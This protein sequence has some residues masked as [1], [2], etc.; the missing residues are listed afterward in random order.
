[1]EKFE[2]YNLDLS[3]KE[4]ELVTKYLDKVNH[5]VKKHDIDN[6]LYQDIEE[7]VFEKLS[8]E[9]KLDQLKIIK[10]LKEVGEPEI[11][12]SDYLDEDDKKEST[13]EKELFFIKLEKNGWIRNNK[14]AWVLG[15]SE[16]LADKAGLPILF[17]RIILILLIFVGGISIWLYIIAGIL[18]PIK[19]KDYSE[20][21][22]MKF[23]KYQIVTV[24][25]DFVFNVTR[26][27]TTLIKYITK[28]FGKTIAF[29]VKNIL[30]VF[31]FIICFSIALFFLCLL[32]ALLV[33]GAMYFSSFSI[34]NIDFTSVLPSYFIYGVIAGI[35][36]LAIL[37]ISNFVFAISGKNINSAILSTGGISLL[38]AI[39]FGLATGFDLA[40][41]YSVTNT[42]IQETE[43]DLGQNGSGQLDIELLQNDYNHFI[44]N[45]GYINKI[46][47]ENTTGSIMK[48]SIK[49]TIYG[50]DEILK[51]IQNGINKL[52]L[53]KE[54]TTVIL[55]SEND[56]F[57]N[58]K[59]PFTIIE[60]DIVLTIPEGYK[61]NIIGNHYFN[62]E[63]AS[64]DKKYEKYMGL[65]NDR[66][67]NGLIWY[68]NNEEKFVCDLGDEDLVDAKKQLFQKYIIDN[69]DSI[70]PI[71]HKKRYK[72][73]YI[74]DDGYNAD[75]EF[76]DFNL[77]DTGSLDF[78]FE[79]KSLSIYA[80]VKLEETETGVLI[81][82]FKIDDIKVNEEVFEE[83]Y[84]EDTKEIREYIY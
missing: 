21:D 81:N 48:A 30:P 36:A 5:F 28:K 64:V 74:N 71:K 72:R 2:Q 60:R 20:M 75:W 34:E 25:K 50:N 6:E 84:Y 11:I 18:L 41:K 32:F 76:Y 69:F 38:L 13:K 55:A 8:K 26:S 46:V 66:C 44:V 43:I 56:K 3:K 83:K 47:L 51:E 78:T 37:S 29:V 17:M 24:I 70:S 10:I 27:G 33:I 77:V 53:K 49:N 67:N 54:G 35:I 57:Y 16:R 14:N 31:R 62:I 45:N 63:N 12:F 73:D 59:V 4:Q 23:I 65:I 7:M 1:M 79:D 15:I 68:K 82:D 22:T 19:G 61:F 58:K 9:K 80:N 42:I 40:E 52:I 39:F